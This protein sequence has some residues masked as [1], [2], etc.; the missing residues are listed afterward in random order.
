MGFVNPPPGRQSL[1]QKFIQILRL[2]VIPLAGGF[3]KEGIHHFLEEE[4]IGGRVEAVD[5]SLFP[6]IAA[7]EVELFCEEDIDCVVF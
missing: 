7:V 5:E 3:P 4:A 6:C 2:F 1:V